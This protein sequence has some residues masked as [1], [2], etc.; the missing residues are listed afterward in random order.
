[1]TDRDRLIELFNEIE[2]DPAITCPH[3]KTDKACDT[4]KYTINN[5]LCNHTERTVDYLL[6]NGVTVS[7]LPIGST[8][9]E[10][11]AR[12]KRLALCGYRKCDYAIV[13]DLYFKNAIA[14]G[15][16]FYVQEKK[17]VKYDK[18]RF[19][20]T[21]FKTKEQ[22]ESFLKGCLNESKNK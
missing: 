9:Y 6:A 19:N 13:N 8:V 11:R 18:T 10:I 16:E 4:C 17:F 1:M 14:H 3:Y 20:K 21:V 5:Y 7:P 12:G 22:A 15:L 2:K